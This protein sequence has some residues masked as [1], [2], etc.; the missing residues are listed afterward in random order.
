MTNVLLHP[1]ERILVQLLVDAGQAAAYTATPWPAFW[2]AEPDS[3]DDCMTI[4]GTLGMVDGIDQVTGRIDE[5]HGFQLR[6]RSSRAQD[7]Y[8]KVMAVRA[9]MA[10]NVAYQ[11]VNVLGTQYTVYAIK[12][13]G[14]LPLGK[15]TPR[16]KRSLFTVNGLMTVARR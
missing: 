13:G 10:A 14:I 15:D 3:P 6:V 2:D 11:L 1:P 9:Y 7:G 8:A 12:P 16:S 4:T 5:H